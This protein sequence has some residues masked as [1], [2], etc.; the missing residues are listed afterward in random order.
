[1]RDQRLITTH[2][3]EEPNMLSPIGNIKLSL[4]SIVASFYHQGLHGFILLHTAGGLI[5]QN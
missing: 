3:G 5:G 4:L 2:D 1:L